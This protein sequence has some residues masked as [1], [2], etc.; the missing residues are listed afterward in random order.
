MDLLAILLVVLALFI[1]V[2]GFKLVKKA[3]TFII[4]IGVLVVAIFLLLNGI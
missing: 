2:I 1:I 4:G 3:I